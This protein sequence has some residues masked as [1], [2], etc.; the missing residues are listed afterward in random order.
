MSSAPCR[1][2]RLRG[3]IYLGERGAFCEVC[4]QNL[5]CP[6]P[7]GARETT[8]FLGGE[9]STTCSWCGDEMPD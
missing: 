7:P 4:N 8:E 3:P 6:H 1:H 9:S 5:P 2:P